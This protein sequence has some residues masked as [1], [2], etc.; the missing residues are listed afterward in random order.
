MS[1]WRKATE[2][3][4]PAM[5][6]SPNH[7][8]PKSWPSGIF[9]KMRGRETKPRSKA[10]PWAMR[11][12]WAMPKKATATGMAIVPPRMTS[13]NSLTEDVASPFRVISSFSR[14]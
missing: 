8:A 4:I 10:P 5:N 14:T 1:G 9:W 11:V 7:M 12:V 2:V 6:R 13:A 3:V